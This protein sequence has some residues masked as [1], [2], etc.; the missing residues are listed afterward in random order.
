M[1][2][3]AGAK[4]FAA[5]GAAGL[6]MFRLMQTVLLIIRL[7]T[8]TPGKRLGTTNTYDCFITKM[9]HLNT[10]RKNHSHNHKQIKARIQP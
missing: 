4:L 1:I 8:I 6:T 5:K 2:Y 7:L 9:V 10:S 3:L